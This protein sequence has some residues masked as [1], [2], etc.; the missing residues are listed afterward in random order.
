[1]DTTPLTYDISI[2]EIFD[3]EHA[4]D[5]F[6]RT[7]G[8]MVDDFK[9]IVDDAEALLQAT[10][11]VPGDAFATERAKLGEKLKKAKARLAEVEQRVFEKAKQAAK[12]TDHSV[13]DN[14]WTAVGVS[15]AIGM[16]IGFLVA[17]R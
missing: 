14:P 17:K 8:R 13:H 9:N 10:A 3:M 7:K 11:K 6:N 12:V 2:Q 1:M 4:L 16:L 15:A 5:E